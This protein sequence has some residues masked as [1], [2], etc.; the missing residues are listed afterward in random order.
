MAQVV[1]HLPSKS[2]TL[3]SNSIAKRQNQIKQKKTKKKLIKRYSF[4]D[5]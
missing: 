5:K 2:K 1:Q 3:S 4:I